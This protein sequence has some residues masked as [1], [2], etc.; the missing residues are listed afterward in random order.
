MR[1]LAFLAISSALIL[2]PISVPKNSLKFLLIA[3][4]TGGRA[5]AG[6]DCSADP[7]YHNINMSMRLLLLNSRQSLPPAPRVQARR[8][9]ETLTPVF[10]NIL[11]KKCV[12][13]EDISSHEGNL[14]FW[15]TLETDLAGYAF[16]MKMWRGGRYSIEDV[17][18]GCP[19]PAA[20]HFAVNELMFVSG[21]GDTGCSLD[22]R[23]EG[24]KTH[25]FQLL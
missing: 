3:M 22:A 11:A 16:R 9:A 8:L 10:E 14:Y 25:L 5:L 4:G 18:Q 1:E 12:L 20:S 15:S 23:R 7:D 6:V 17:G 19:C 24:Q 21:G 2:I 13:W